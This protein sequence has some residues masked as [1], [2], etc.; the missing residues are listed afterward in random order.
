MKD[1]QGDKKKR[2]Q[3]K[4]YF[5]DEVNKLPYY[6][7]GA[8]VAIALAIDWT[9][10]L[11][12]GVAYAV[13][14]VSGKERCTDEQ[15]D[16]WLR[17]DLDLFQEE[18]LRKTRLDKLDL[19]RKSVIMVGNRWKDTAGAII[20]RRK[21]EDGKIR[22]TPL[23]VT[24]IQFT[25]HQLV[26]YQTCFDFTTGS[27][28]NTGTKRF[29]Y[30]DVVSAETQATN[31][32]IST[33]E[34]SGELRKNFPQIDQHITNDVLQLHQAEMFSLTTRGGNSIQVVLNEPDY[35]GKVGSSDF[36]D[37]LTDQ[38]INAVNQMLVSKKGR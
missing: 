28:L 33:K 2:E 14:K 20:H 10:L 13:H 8:G 11:L 34:I 37:R 24:I 22:H 26:T 6:I 35:L 31:L 25:E 17:N 5:S 7:G 36:T 4:N 9:G 19:V 38:A 23:D 3:I 15:Y 12:C 18:A 29:F 16:L 30:D 32:S 21:G 1:T 27:A